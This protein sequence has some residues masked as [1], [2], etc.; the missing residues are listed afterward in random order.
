LLQTAA[1]GTAAAL[2]TSL[3]PSRA[4]A[5][6]D[7]RIAIVGAGLAGLSAAYALARAGIVADV[8]EASPRVGGRTW[9]ERRAFPGLVAERGGELIDTEHREIRALAAEL[10]LTL[11]DLIEAESKGTDAVFLFDGR[12]YTLDEATADFAALLPALEKDARALGDEMPTFRDHTPAQLALDRMSA[13]AWIDARVP[14]GLASRLGRLIANAYIEEL[15]GDLYEISAAT[16]V[17]LLRASP[18]ERFS[19]YEESDQRFHVRGGNDQIATTLAERLPGTVSTS[20]RLLAVARR[21]DGRYR[22]T[23]SRDQATRDAIADRVVLAIPF[24]LLRQCDLA[25]AGLRPRKQRAIRELGMG[26]NTKLQLRFTTRHWEKLGCNG[27]TRVEGVYQT[28]WE[29]TRAQ[30]DPAGVLNCYSGGSTAT[31]AGEG[32]TEERALEALADLERALPGLTPTW[33]GSAIRNAWERHPWAQGSYSLFRPGQYTAF[34]GILHE[35]EGALHFAG[36]H[37]SIDWQGYMNGG[38]ESGLRAADEI[39]R[40]LTRRSRTPVQTERRPDPRAPVAR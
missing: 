17:A 10:G 34:N 31:R 18:R 16:V 25:A 23:F 24:T 8:Y 9:S 14:G 26:R 39:A 30:Q 40:A 2:P 27:E 1:L 36:E 29:V 7:A 11:D 32:E 38:V 22:L 21:G 33:T 28:S 5:A 13:T 37:T 35:A 3:F 19:P 6:A 4:A 12:R 20:Q 15:G